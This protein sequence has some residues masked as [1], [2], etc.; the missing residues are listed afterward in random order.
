MRRLAAGYTGRGDRLERP[1]RR[2]LEHIFADDLSAVRVHTD[3]S[4]GQVCQA[5]RAASA[6]GPV[7]LAASEGALNHSASYVIVNGTIWRMHGGPL[8][9]FFREGAQQVTDRTL[10]SLAARANTISIYPVATQTAEQTV[11]WWSSQLARG[12][13]AMFTAAEGCAGS[14][15]AL[16]NRA[17]IAGMEGLAGGSRFVNPLFPL[18]LDE[19]RMAG[20]AGT[21]IV[22]N[23][24]GAAAAR[25]S[26]VQLG[27]QALVQGAARETAWAV[28]W[29]SALDQRYEV[30][31]SARQSGA[32][33]LP[34]SALTAAP[35]D[36]LEGVVLTEVS[37]QEFAAALSSYVT[38]APPQEIVIQLPSGGR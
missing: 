25:G 27:T 14:Q 19:A 22:T 34:V 7:V 15:V 28:N 11:Q 9:M 8:Q 1:L 10:T 30:L 21:H 23:Q 31:S 6:Q 26:A 35:A 38:T 3:A 17:G 2:W 12:R 33:Q 37:P 18:F 5:V 29:S 20:T 13:F 24:F 32:N 4:A 16:L 36:G